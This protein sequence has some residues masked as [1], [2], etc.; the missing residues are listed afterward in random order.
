MK[1]FSA[2]ME[3]IC[4]RWEGNNSLMYDGKTQDIR[5]PEVCGGRGLCQH[6]CGE[7]SEGEVRVVFTDL[8]SS[9]C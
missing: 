7:V 2:R 1:L 3:E 4:V 6:R 5:S 9:C 8:E